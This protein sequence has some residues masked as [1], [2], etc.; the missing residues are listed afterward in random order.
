MIIDYAI[1]SPNIHIEVTLW[2]ANDT[3]LMATYRLESNYVK[4]VWGKYEYEMPYYVIFQ[5][6]R[7]CVTNCDA[8]EYVEINSLRLD[9]YGQQRNL[10]LL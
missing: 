5:V 7:V 10:E 9:F 1:S 8:I 6:I 4:L 2:S 3:D